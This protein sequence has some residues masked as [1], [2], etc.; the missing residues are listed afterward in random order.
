MWVYIWIWKTVSK[1][2]GVVLLTC[3][4]LKIKLS[5]WG[6][7]SILSFHSAPPPNGG[8]TTPTDRVWGKHLFDS[9]QEKPWLPRK[10][11]SLW[12]SYIKE[13]RI[14]SSKL[15]RV[16][17]VNSSWFTPMGFKDLFNW[18]IFCGS[19]ITS[20]LMVKSHRIRKHSPFKYLKTK[21]FWCLL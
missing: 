12:I 10:D 19:I 15:R 9:W 5:L 3:V 8:V 20:F 6:K 7:E 21:K 17:V 11:C 2:R 13:K 1:F 14:L 16:C 4:N 18:Q